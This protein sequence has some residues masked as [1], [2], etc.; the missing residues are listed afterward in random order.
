MAN[1]DVLGNLLIEL[2]EIRPND[3]EVTVLVVLA[4]REQIVANVQIRL[5]ETQ[6]VHGSASHLF[7]VYLNPAIMALRERYA[8]R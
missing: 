8:D 3:E 4:N 1:R 7:K 2:S 5:T 6:F